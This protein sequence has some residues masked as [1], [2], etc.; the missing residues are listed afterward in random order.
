MSKY[1]TFKN[2]WWLPT[3]H[4]QTIY[5]Y[6]FLCKRAPSYTRETI[7][8]RDG[9]F[10]DFDW[11]KMNKNSP[12][13]VVFHGLEGSSK[14]HYASAIMHLLEKRKWNGVVAH[15]R[16]CSGR[17][18][19]LLR[20]Y[21][22]GDHEDVDFIL[23][24]IRQ[25][26]RKPIFCIGVSLGGLALL[27]WAIHK[28]IKSTNI[29]KAVAIVSAPL[30]LVI[31]GHRL[32]LGFNKIYSWNFL[33]SL[34]KKCEEKLKKFGKGAM[35]LDMQ[36]TKTIKDFD[37]LYTAPVH[38]FKNVCHYW[39]NSSVLDK[40]GSV[41][42]NTILIHSNNDPFLPKQYLPD[43]STLPPNVH[44]LYTKSGGHA[45]FTTGSFPGNISWLPMT[46]MSFF[47]SFR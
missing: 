17:P 5:P 20:A 10:L 26:T 44:C 15:F 39:S 43:P 42:L 12:T 47:D 31:T 8:L 9:D 32:S 14:S 28:K 38:G 33:K 29:L 21:H 6:L 27:N 23:E 37:D 34:K 3:G 4:L 46:I 24:T 18:N 25:R 19:D 2:P 40:L 7:K 35:L 41:Q 36:K 30:N 11:L 1:R 16:G 13:V 45:G 22:A